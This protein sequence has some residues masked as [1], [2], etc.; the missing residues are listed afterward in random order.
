MIRFAGRVVY[1]T[2]H[3]G[4]KVFIF[5]FGLKISGDLTKP[6]WCFSFCGFTH[7]RL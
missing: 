2:K 6:G 3:C 5:N 1:S 7:L 4:Y